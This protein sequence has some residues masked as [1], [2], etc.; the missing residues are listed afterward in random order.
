LRLLLLIGHYRK[1]DH[2]GS[3]AGGK[4]VLFRQGREVTISSKDLIDIYID[5]EQLPGSQFNLKILPGALPLR[6]PKPA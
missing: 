6:L 4:K 1:G 3:K 2:I 5:G